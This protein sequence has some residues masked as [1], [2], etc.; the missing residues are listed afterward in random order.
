MDAKVQVPEVLDL[1]PFRGMGLQ[2]GEVLIPDTDGRHIQ[3]T[4]ILLTVFNSLCGAITLCYLATRL[5]TW[6]D[7]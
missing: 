6:L 7:L 2:P 5:V 4:L 1:T 3:P